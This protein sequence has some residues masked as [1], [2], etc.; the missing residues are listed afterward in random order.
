[1][2]CFS[3]HLG[4]ELVRI[5]VREILVLFWQGIQQVEVFLFCE[6]VSLLF[7]LIFHDTW[8]Y[9]YK[10]LVI[11]DAFQLLGADAQ[12]VTNLVRQALEVPNVNYRN[13]QLDV[14]HAFTAYFLF[15][16]LYTTTVTNNTLVTDPLVLSASTFVVF[17]WTKNLFTEQTI[18]LGLVGSVV[19]GLWF[20]HLTKR[21]VQDR[22]RGRNANGDL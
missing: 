5:F 8:L 7:A 10:T 6:Q 16:H 18:A 19:D 13:H 20:Q 22:I 17:H 2:Y 4:D 12:Q 1:M 14:P 21:P 9:H 11:N 3:T 15:G